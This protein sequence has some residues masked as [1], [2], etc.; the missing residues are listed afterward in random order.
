MPTQGYT[1]TIDRGLAQRAKL[2]YYFP[3]TEGEAPTV[4]SV[5]FFENPVIRERKRARYKKYALV[6]RSSDLY[7]YLGAESRKISVEFFMSFPHILE[8]APGLTREKIT[9]QQRSYDP[10]VERAR[11]KRSQDKGKDYT[12]NLNRTSTRLTEEFINLEGM[13]GA[14]LNVLR[15]EWA[16]KGASPAELTYIRNTYQL[17][18]VDVTTNQ[19]TGMAVGLTTSL[20]MGLMG[21][22]AGSQ[23]NYEIQGPT[24]T[25]KEAFKSA[26]TDNTRYRILDLLVYWVNIIRSSV[27]NK[28]DNPI[29]GPPIIR[30]THGLMYQ[31]IPCICTDYDISWEERAGY[32]LHTLMPRRIK[33][34]L[35]LEELRTGDFGSFSDHDPTI[36]GDPIRNDNLGG[37]ESIISEPY[38]LDP[39]TF[40]GF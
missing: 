31:N 4:I 36:M 35:N 13:K 38:T 17:T 28:A 9:N 20:A 26:A 25:D 14:A 6:A 34:S 32:D 23:I 3:G 8:E 27:I 7:A 29:M 22:G 5:P 21:F 2:K 24:P 19:L 16:Q 33:V 37:W 1:H 39:G 15:S 40:Q 12:D 11:F 18:D 30:L 10:S